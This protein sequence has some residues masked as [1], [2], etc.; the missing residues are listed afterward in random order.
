MAALDQEK[1]HQLSRNLQSAGFSLLSTREEILTE[2][3]KTVL[4]GMC[5]TGPDSRKQKLSAFLQDRFHMSYSRLSVLFSETA[6]LTIESYFIRLRIEKAREYLSYPDLTIKEI[7]DKLGFSSPAHLASAFK[8]TT[9]MTMTAY[10]NS[11]EPNRLPLDSIG[12]QIHDHSK[13]P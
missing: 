7:A 9:G 3:I 1:K 2:G 5:D 11:S 13:T 10:R 8:K 4:L 12:S 6:G